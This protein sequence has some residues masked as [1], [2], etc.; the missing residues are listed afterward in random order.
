MRVT[1]HAQPSPTPSAASPVD[2]NIDTSSAD[3]SPPALDSR[4]PSMSTPPL[5][6]RQVLNPPP[7]A[8]PVEAAVDHASLTLA[9]A[10]LDGP[11]S[12]VLRRAAPVPPRFEAR[13]RNYP[14]LT[15]WQIEQSRHVHAPLQRRYAALFKPS[16]ALGSSRSPLGQRRAPSEHA[17]AVRMLLCDEGE[18]SRNDSQLCAAAARHAS[19]SLDGQTAE[20]RGENGCDSAQ[21]PES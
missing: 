9:E 12:S 18:N 17:A 1:P 5:K 16:G 7:L 20:H 10:V 21:T 3:C 4:Q 6:R 2:A 19:R 8:K 15:S 13:I 14:D 11:D